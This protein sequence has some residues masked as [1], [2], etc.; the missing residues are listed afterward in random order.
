M[1]HKI[2]YVSIKNFELEQR[3]KRN[4]FTFDAFEYLCQKLGY[5]N[6]SALRKMCEPRSNGSS[7]A[8]LGVEDAMILMTEMNDYRLLNFIKEELKRR[9]TECQQIDMFSKPQ[10]E[11]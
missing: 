4:D 9:K 8:K 10:T 1:M 11:L 5:K 6:T 2:L 7:A 3:L